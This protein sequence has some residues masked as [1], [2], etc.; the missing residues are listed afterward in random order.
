MDQPIYKAMSYLPPRTQVVPKSLYLILVLFFTAGCEKESSVSPPPDIKFPSI[1]V[2]ED[3]TDR[4]WIMG[5]HNSLSLQ[6]ADKAGLRSLS[7]KIDAGGCHVDSGVIS[8]RGRIALV[9]TRIFLPAKWPTGPAILKL[10]CRNVDGVITAERTLPIEAVD[11]MPPSIHLNS[12]R[13]EIVNC[14]V[15]DPAGCEATYEFMSVGSSP[16]SAQLVNLTGQIDEN[17]ELAQLNWIYYRNGGGPSEAGHFD[18]RDYLYRRE[19]VFPDDAPGYFEFW[20]TDLSGNVSAV[21]TVQ[22]H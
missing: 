19:Y 17:S 8:I 18:F 2:N 4:T 14:I 12:I 16:Q 20:A 22:V 7:Y 1:T 11:A 3:A 6:C 10:K 21:Q 9:D 13:S 5:D 15:V